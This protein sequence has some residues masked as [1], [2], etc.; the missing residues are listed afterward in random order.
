MYISERYADFILNIGLN[1]IP[2]DVIDRAKKCLIDS[3]ACNFGGSQ[4]KTGQIIIDVFKKLEI[5]GTS[6]VIG[7]NYKLPPTYAGYINSKIANILDYDDTYLGIGHPGATI[8]PPSLAVAESVNASGEDILKAVI[9]GYEVSC[10]IGDAIQP[11]PER[12]KQIWGMGSWQVFGALAATSALL[13]LNKEE[14]V[15]A[16]GIAGSNAPIASMRK[17]L[18]TPLGVTMVKNNFDF[19]AH[20][21]ILSALLAKGGYTGAKN[22]FEGNT[23]FWRMFGS[24]QCDFDKLTKNLGIDYE[25]MK[26]DFKPYPMCRWCQPAVEAG[27]EI[28]EKNNIGVNNIKKVVIKVAKQL[29]ERPYSIV[30]PT[31]IEEAVFSLP[32]PFAVALC[33]VELGPLWYTEETM[34]DP[35]ILN[36]SRKVKLVHYLEAEKLFPK[37]CMATI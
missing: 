32:Y 15:N 36:L 10:R 33:N 9:V 6:T 24:D 21:G 30:E 16:F 4:T 37:K 14:I 19:A 20:T 13:N 5:S 1:E 12:F 29:T 28:I 23:G 31:N 25:I 18:L 8:V 11:T 3:I 27:L 22:I 17:A 26:I 7:A 35:G 34:S 2:Q